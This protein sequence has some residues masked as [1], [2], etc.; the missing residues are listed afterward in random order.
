MA[1]A[2]CYINIINTKDDR[3]TLQE[4]LNTLQL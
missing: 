4:D 1:V 3:L 2:Y